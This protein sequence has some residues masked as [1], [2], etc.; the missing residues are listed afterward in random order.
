MKY[1][2]LPGCELF[3]KIQEINTRRIAASMSAKSW[4]TNHF[5]ESKPYSKPDWSMGGG[6][7]DIQLNHKP[8]GWK[9]V[10]DKWQSFFTP[11][12]NQKKILDEWRALPVVRNDEIKTLLN[13]GNYYGA[14]NG[15]LVWNTMP[16]LLITKDVILVDCSEVATDYIP[17]EGMEEILVSEF[18]RI[19]QTAAT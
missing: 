14:K 18:N 15:G 10:G 8:E 7:S 4:I 6:I 19:Y 1:K 2:I 17:V 12:A 13:Y 11:K 5:G 3:D 9:Q 16:G